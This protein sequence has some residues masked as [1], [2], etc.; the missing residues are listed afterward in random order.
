MSRRLCRYVALWL[1]VFSV[2]WASLCLAQDK[3]KKPKTADDFIRHAWTYYWIGMVELGDVRSYDTG[4]SYV[5]RAKAA[6][7]SQDATKQKALKSQIE[8]VE[9]ALNQQRDLATITLRGN[10]PLTAFLGKSIFIDATS[11]GTYEIIDEPYDAAVTQMSEILRDEIMEAWGMPMQ[12]DILV[13]SDPPNRTFEN[14]VTFLVERSPKINI[15]PLGTVQK[16][17]NPTAFKLLMDG[18]PLDVP[19]NLARLLGSDRLMV[20]NVKE[21]DI[22]DDIYFYE[23]RAT[24][25]RADRV[26]SFGKVLTK[27]GI[28]RDRRPR[29]VPFV[30]NLL[31]MFIFGVVLIVVLTREDMELW[32]A[33]ALGALGFVAGTASPQVLIT[34]L[35]TIEP[36]EEELVKLAFWWPIAAGLVVTIGPSIVVMTLGNRIGASVRL[37]RRALE[38]GPIMACGIGAGTGAYLARGALVYYDDQT[39][40]IL[41]WIGLMGTIGAARLISGLRLQR[42]PTPYHTLVAVVALLLFPLAFFAASIPATAILG[43]AMLGAT[44]QLGKSQAE[45]EQPEQQTEDE[46]L[47][48]G[49]DALN[50]LVMRAR[51]PS[52]Q[53]YAPFKSATKYL[54]SACDEKMRAQS[55]RWIV[56]QGQKG[57]GKT[58]TSTA[59]LKQLHDNHVMLH[60]ICSPPSNEDLEGDGD[61]HEAKPYEAF[62]QAF[63]DMGTFGFEAEEN[64]VFAELEGTVMDALPIVSMLLP[65]ADEG[66]GR[67][68]SDRGE[69]YARIERE[70]IKKTR[71]N[72][73]TVVLWLDD[74]QWL[75]NAS[76]GLLEHLIGRFPQESEHSIIFLLGGREL[77]V[78]SPMS[79]QTQ[80]FLRDEMICVELETPQRLDMLVESIG[81]SE[82]SAQLL[83]D[84]VTGGEGKSNLAWLLTLVEA[85]A[86]E[87]SVRLEDERYHLTVGS[88]ED[89][90]I[91]ESFKNMVGQTFKDLDRA[92][93]HLLKVATCLGSSFSVEVMHRVMRRTR[94]EILDDLER[95][96]EETHL[97]EDYMASDDV[98]RFVSAQRYVALRDYLHLQDLHPRMQAPQM[99]RDLH[100]HVAREMEALW[101]EQRADV[102]D[103]AHHYYNAGRRDLDNAVAYCELAAGA[104]L[105]VFAYDNAEFQL[106]RAQVCAEMI[107]KNVKKESDRQRA[108][109]KL[110]EIELQLRLLPFEKAHVLGLSQLTSEMVEIAERLFGSVKEDEA[111][112]PLPLLISMARASY[113]GRRFD[114]AL[115]IAQHMVD[116]GQSV[117]ESDVEIELYLH[118]QVVYI[119]GLHFI[120]LSLSPRE[121]AKERLEVLT[122][123]MNV[124]DA[125]SQT[126]ERAVMNGRIDASLWPLKVTAL[127]GRLF[128]SLGEQRSNQVT[129]DFEQARRWFHRSVE[130]KK[131]LTP[132]DK[133]GL[134]RAYGGLGRL[135]LFATTYEE[136]Q[137][138]HSYLKR[139]QHYL[140]ED[141]GLCR[142]Y[143]DVA[144]ECQ[145]HS[146]L[147]Q[148]ALRQGAPE[149]AVHHYES[150]LELASST[151]NTA[152]GLVGLHDAVEAMNEAAYR[153]KVIDRIIAFV[154]DGGV[155][156]FLST[157]FLAILESSHTDPEAHEGYDEAVTCLQPPKPANE[158]E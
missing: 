57:S 18:K 53:G 137:D 37:L 82:D 72:T 129:Y 23:F 70:L 47:A 145:M 80:A 13:V 152:F 17:L 110:S 2:F 101:R 6:L 157:K 29:H 52:Y 34:F 73:R 131:S 9:E 15:I 24:L 92:D 140:E 112:L 94:L 141:I 134:A 90:P 14:K 103:V 79:E 121:E 109:A 31:A 144:G 22:V 44:W 139:A 149:R 42:M 40:W 136:G 59:L 26:K 107:L 102:S 100:Y 43:V 154:L 138:E 25:Q 30:L 130:I 51:Q 135:Y 11:M 97:V 16:K 128:N 60:G 20:I 91:P 71:R 84:A 7:K 119:E 4:L 83:D 41:A 48:L 36:Q 75:D 87:G 113:D 150:S 67:A 115:E 104:A 35:E 19:G 147:G 155:P 151:I 117:T 78:N 125:L 27:R 3:K 111:S 156:P 1:V 77:P 45:E 123:A 28:I 86:R 68:V 158:S 55:V 146:H 46:S 105:D 54:K 98:F 63:G 106:K 116:V 65:A 118:H 39:G 58:A 95:L 64:D 132:Q 126:I 38:Y 21:I 153:A 148:C 50:T 122:D 93:Q 56:L 120:G 89:L 62:V 127:K 61:G 133:P 5:K 76:Q 96:A 142:D 49:S 143:G 85:V 69:I 108:Q 81:F 99:L 88:S 114:L 66:G 124:A 74:I 8:Q 33:I 10:F 32:E 12:T